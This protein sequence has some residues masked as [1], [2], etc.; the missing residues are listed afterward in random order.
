MSFNW[1]VSA[2]AR[3]MKSSAIREILKITER[4]DIISFAG[5]LPAPELFPIQALKEACAKVLDT[6]GPKSLQYS[7]TMGVLPL[8]EILA[9]RLSKKGLPVTIDN[10]F[11]TGGSQQGLDLVAK[12]FLNEGDAL[13]CENPTYLGAI[14]AFNVMRPKYVTVEMDQ[15]GMIV[16]QAEEKIKE[17][18]PRFIYVVADFQN[19]SGITM[20][21]KRRKQL[22]TLAEKYQ[23]P[24]VDDNPY[25]ELRYVGE[26]LP[27]LQSMGKDLVI[28]LGTFS[29]IVSPGLRIGWGIISTEIT[30]MFE[31]LKQGADLHTNTFAQYVVYEYI[32]AGNLDRHIEEIKASYS[33]RRGVMIEALK[34]H[35]PEDV[36]WYEPEGGLFLW[37]E[38]PQ[39]ISATDLLPVAVEEKVAYVPGKPFYPHE[40][41]DNTLRLNFSNANPDLIREGIKRL[42]KVLREN[43]KALN[44]KKEDTEQKVS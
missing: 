31:R 18:N 33:E 1:T 2:R 7:L 19:P 17:H 34:E 21:L 14:Q 16:E 40:D 28:E 30:T 36:K 37:V 6:H 9:E 13:L 42:G 15:E 4:P 35:F 24:I 38:L 27:S 29:K 10:L 23:I 44:L 8:R 43:V 32:K 3:E 12:V 41:K 11:I 22:V 26:P 39:G 25:G 5:G 20:S